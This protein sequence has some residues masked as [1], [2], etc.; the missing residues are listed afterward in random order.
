MMAVRASVDRRHTQGLLEQLARGGAVRHRAGNDVGGKSPASQE[1]D[2]A[3]RAH[4]VGC[5]EDH[6]SDRAIQRRLLKKSIHPVR[7][8]DAVSQ[9]GDDEIRTQLV[10]IMQK[11]TGK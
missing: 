4:V 1:L 10:E 5:G 3:P 11:P 9:L 7:T 2:T 8:Q 6:D